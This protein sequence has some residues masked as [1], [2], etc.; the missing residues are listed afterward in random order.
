M[1]LPGFDALMLFWALPL[2]VLGAVGIGYIFYLLWVNMSP[3]FAL[4]MAWVFGPPVLMGVCLLCETRT[5][6]KDNE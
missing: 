4:L 2:I 1:K 3:W 6:K 5:W